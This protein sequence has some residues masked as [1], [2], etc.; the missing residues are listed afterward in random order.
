MWQG[1][2]VS[3]VIPAYN[4]GTTIRQIA[5]AF[6]RAPGVDE[7][8]VVDNNSTD[9]TA[10]EAGKTTARV[11]R[12]ERQGY[13]AA[14]RRGLREA[15]G[16]LIVLTEADGTYRADDLIKLL[17]YADRFELVKG[18]RTH[19]LMLAR[20]AFPLALRLFIVVGNFALAKLMQLLFWG[21]P[22]T[23]A[24]CT[25]RL[26]TRGAL[27]KIQPYFSVD[28]GHFLA[29]MTVLAMIKRIQMIEIPLHFSQRL[30]G[31]SS[32]GGFVGL[33]KIGFAMV[34]VM[35]RY[36]VRSWSKNF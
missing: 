35:L 31:T 17:A 7:V 16:D 22:L 32:S 21:P 6:A 9:Q 12:E 10:A 24:D 8:V 3:V 4:E 23:D 28:R 13:G 20:D 33:L 27:A 26:I 14:C 25:M 2:R 30:G 19:R 29:E 11:V 15:T 18:T 34:G 5:A 1:K 36:R